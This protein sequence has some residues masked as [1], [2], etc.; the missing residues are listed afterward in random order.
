MH[1][2]FVVRERSRYK[3]DVDIAGLAMDA[4]GFGVYAEACGQALALYHLRAFC[5][6]ETCAPKDAKVPRGRACTCAPCL[7]RFRAARVFPPTDRPCRARD[8][9]QWFLVARRRCAWPGADRCR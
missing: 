4:K 9:Y 6:D 1:K 8:A 3:G 5:A 7:V 2:S